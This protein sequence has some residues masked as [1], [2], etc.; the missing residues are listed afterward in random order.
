MLMAAAVGRHCTLELFQ[1]T[2]RQVNGQLLG[3]P[4]NDVFCVFVYVYLH[5]GITTR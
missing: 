1:R 4:V 5:I 3:V 2:L